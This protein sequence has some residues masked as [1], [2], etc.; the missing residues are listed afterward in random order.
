LSGKSFDILFGKKIPD[1]SRKKFPIFLEIFFNFLSEK[2]FLII[3]GKKVSTSDKNNSRVFS[4]KKSFQSFFGK[5]V[6]IFYS[7]KF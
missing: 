5:K 2:I 7:K 4:G 3:S 1:F 6:S